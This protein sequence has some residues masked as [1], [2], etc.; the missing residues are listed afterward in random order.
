M[1]RSVLMKRIRSKRINHQVA[2]DGKAERGNRATNHVE[3]PISL[4]YIRNSLFVIP[5]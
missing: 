3:I 5:P 2:L 1:D 4:P